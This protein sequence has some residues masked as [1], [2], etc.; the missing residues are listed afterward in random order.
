MSRRYCD[1]K[2]DGEEK[3]VNV[4]DKEFAPMVP[5]GMTP[6][7][8]EDCACLFAPDPLA[9]FLAGFAQLVSTCLVS[10]RSWVRFPEEAVPFAF[11]FLRPPDSF[12][13]AEWYLMEKHEKDPRYEESK[14]QNT[15]PVYFCLSLYFES[16]ITFLFI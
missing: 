4:V 14:T 11:S 15:D 16:N 8:R 6:V 10:R 7:F 1:F 13:E 9:A 12:G 3:R 2:D 5:E